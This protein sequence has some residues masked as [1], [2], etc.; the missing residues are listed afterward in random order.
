MVNSLET[1]FFRPI[2]K[3]TTHNTPFA[4]FDTNEQE[5][6]IEPSLSAPPNVGDNADNLV[7]GPVSFRDLQRRVGES[8]NVIEEVSPRRFD[9]PMFDQALKQKAEPN[10]YA[11]DPVTIFKKC[12]TAK[13]KNSATTVENPMYDVMVD[14]AKEVSKENIE[15]ET[16]GQ[17]HF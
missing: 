13:D 11:P 7:E 9:N 3:I 10:I 5:V 6:E 14:I 12:K 4:R 1:I 8:N 2:Q 16:K 15:V 17:K